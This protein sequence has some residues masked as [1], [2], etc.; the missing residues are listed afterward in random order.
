MISITKR[1]KEV[2][3]LLVEGKKNHEISSTLFIS[4][5]TV[6]AILEKIYYKTKCHNRVQVVVWA[7]KNN[8]V[9]LEEA[10]E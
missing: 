2:I 3:E 10:C 9:E 6:K 7:I 4:T 1:E 8:V 5:H